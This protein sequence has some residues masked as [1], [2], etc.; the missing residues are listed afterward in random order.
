[1]SA[2]LPVVTQRAAGRPRRAAV[3][4]V[5]VP[6]APLW[7]TKLS[8]PIGGSPPCAAPPKVH[9]APEPTFIAPRQFGPRMRIPVRVA[10]A[11][12]S[13]CAASPSAPTSPKPDA[14]T[15]AA[16]TPALAH[17]SSASSVPAAGMASTARS[18]G[19]G[20]LAMSGNAGSPCTTVWRRLMGYT[21]PLK[22]NRSRLATGLPP[23]R[24]GSAEAPSTAIERG[25]NSAS[26]PLTPPPAACC[27]TGIATGRG[28]RCWPR[29]PPA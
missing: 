6:N 5:K 14:N 18:T 12:S 9:T 2:S 28:C 29:P 4:K 16:P 8:P 13:A 7:L 27:R 20:T 22:P 24:P 1:M 10:S 3:T 11:P 25:S 17:A 15:M 23:M 19:P 26:R 21:G